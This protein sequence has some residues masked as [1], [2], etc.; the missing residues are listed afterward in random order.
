MTMD[1]QRT[2][3]FNISSVDK[4]HMRLIA[5]LVCEHVNV[6]IKKLFDRTRIKP[7]VNARQIFFYFCSQYLDDVS[8][9]SLTRAAY[10]WGSNRIYNHAT[11]LHAIKQIDNYI[12]SDI[13]FRE[14]MQKLRCEIEIAVMQSDEISNSLKIKKASQTIDMLLKELQDPF[15]AEYLV[16]K[17]KNLID[18]RRNQDLHEDSGLDMV[19]KSI[20]V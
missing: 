4:A 5:K 1:K 7:I 15:Y 2:Y 9:S 12:F 13:R 11:V 14:D 3:R 16:S 8:K 17:L 18:E 6:P 20:H 19:Q 10:L